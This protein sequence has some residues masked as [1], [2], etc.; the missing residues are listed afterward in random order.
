MSANGKENDGQNL[1]QVEVRCDVATRAQGSPSPVDSS[2]LPIDQLTARTGPLA[3]RHDV[4]PR[5]PA[6]VTPAADRVYHGGKEARKEDEGGPASRRRPPPAAACRGMIAH[7]DRFGAAP[8]Q[9]GVLD[10]RR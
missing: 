5:A 2:R 10:V 8:L 6:E 1:F 3:R 4:G 9:P 7:L